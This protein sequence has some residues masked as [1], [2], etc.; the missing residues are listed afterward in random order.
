MDQFLAENHGNT[1][2]DQGYYLRGLARYRQK[3]IPAAKADFNQ[4]A[5]LSKTPQIKGRAFKALGDICYDSADMPVAA[6]MYRQGLENLDQSIPPADEARYRLGQALQRL[7]LWGQADIQFS[8]L[9]YQFPGSQLARQAGRNIYATAWTI[10]TPCVR[11]RRTAQA[12]A[13]ELKAK[14]QDVAAVAALASDEGMM[15]VVQ[16]G[17]FATYEQAAELYE[18][19]QTIQADARITVVK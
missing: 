1:Q 15:F 14:G 17:R 9:I 6:E 12:T 19:V 4:A 8:R 3:D 11:D 10:Q 18:K 16:V 7:G 13:D 5:A 2:A